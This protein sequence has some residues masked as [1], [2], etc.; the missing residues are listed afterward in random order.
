[1]DDVNAAT[2]AIREAFEAEKTIAYLTD[3]ARE[4]RCSMYV[5]GVGRGGTHD[6]R[7]GASSCRV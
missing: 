6:R 7:S 4:K 2:I 3:E 1:M 5:E